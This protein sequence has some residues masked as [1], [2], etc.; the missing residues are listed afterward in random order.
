MSASVQSV[1]RVVEV[2]N[3]LQ[4]LEVA[5]MHVRL[6][7]IGTRP[8]VYVAQS[9]DLNFAVKQGCEPRPFFRVWVYPGTY[10]WT[11]GLTN[12]LSETDVG[13]ETANSYV[14][15]FKSQWVRDIAELVRL[16]LV[17]KRES[18]ILRCTDVS[19]G[20]VGK[21][22]RHICRIRRCDLAPVNIFGSSKWQVLH[23]PLPRNRF[24]PSSSSLVNTDLVGLASA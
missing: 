8:H 9:W 17:Q 11:G 18:K 3:G 21:Q 22:R 20:E 15:V 13:E 7:E 23:L 16:V 1:A 5:V 24:Q 6:H 2:D 10:T 14:N 12:L 19:R 4:A